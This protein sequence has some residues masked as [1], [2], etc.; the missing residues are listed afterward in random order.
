MRGPNARAATPA[1]AAAAGDLVVVRIP[2]RPSAAVSVHQHVGQPVVDL[3]NYI[4]ERD[5]GYAGC[6]TWP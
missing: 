3:S 6:T 5:H 2:P 1:K 4:P